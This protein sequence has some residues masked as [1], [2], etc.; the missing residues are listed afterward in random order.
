[1]LPFT[2]MSPSGPSPPDSLSI[3]WRLTEVTTRC[4]TPSSPPRFSQKQPI[5]RA[6]MLIRPASPDTV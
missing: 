1:M 2:P 4:T 3:T 6:S 5:G